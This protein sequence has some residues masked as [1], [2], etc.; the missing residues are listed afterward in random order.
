MFLDPCRKFRRRLSAHLDGELPAPEAE[1]LQAHL[2]SCPSCSAGLAALRAL[3]ADLKAMP[4]MEPSSFFAARAVA[5]AKAPRPEAGEYRR[6]LRLPVPVMALMLGLMSAGLFSFVLNV[7][8][9]DPAQRHGLL[10]RVVSGMRAPDS[11]I[12]PVALGR[13]CGNCAA[14]LCDCKKRCDMTP[15]KQCP[16]CGMDEAKEKQ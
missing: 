1:A 16:V 12:N 8:A 6:F 9:M 15:G 10:N 11:L 7:R 14:Y 5:A 3:E 13:L 4:G 2:A